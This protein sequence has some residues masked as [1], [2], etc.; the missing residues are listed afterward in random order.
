MSA[1][2]G[3]SVARGERR[4]VPPDL[5]RQCEGRQIF[6]PRLRRDALAAPCLAS[7]HPALAESAEGSRHF[8]ASFTS[9]IEFLFAACRV[10]LESASFSTQLNWRRSDH[11]RNE[12]TNFQASL[13]LG[14]WMA[15]KILLR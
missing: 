13:D 12:Q 9:P 2:R 14:S 7:R 5:R 8:Q 10:H 3:S 11:L 1:D 15:G 4:V 6:R